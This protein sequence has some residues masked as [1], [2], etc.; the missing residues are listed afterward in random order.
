M[1]L[2]LA[3]AFVF[4]VPGKHR[5]AFYGFSGYRKVIFIVSMQIAR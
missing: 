3:I 5:S 2:I 4:V 1:C